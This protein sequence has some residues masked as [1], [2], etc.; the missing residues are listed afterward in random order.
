MSKGK[1]SQEQKERKE[2]LELYRRHINPSLARLLKMMAADRVEFWGRGSVIYDEEGK[3]YID[4]LG[5]YGT[6][7]LGHAHPVVVQAVRRQLSRMP[8]SSKI[9]LNRP[10]ALLAEKIAQLAPSPLQFS[11]FCN[12]GAEAVEGAIKIA[13]LATGK[14]KIISC[15]NA[16]HGKTLGALSVSGRE[17]YREPF[18]PLLPDCVQI[19][20]ND[21]AA[22]EAAIDD[23]TAAFLVEPIQGEG[24]VVVPDLGYLKACAELCRKKGV[25]LVLDEVQTG[26]GRCGRLFCFQNEEI[27]PDILLLGKALGGGVMPLAAIVGTEAVFKSLFPNPLLHTSTFGGN[28]LSC[29]A[30]LAALDVIEC[31]NLVERARVMGDYFIR[32]LTALQE[33]FNEICAS[34]RG[35]G[36]MIGVEVTDEAVGGILM[37]EMLKRGVLVA[38]TLNNPRVIRF[39][40]PLIIQEKEIRF[41]LDALRASLGK[42]RAFL[43]EVSAS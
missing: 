41:V 6:F 13:R 12:S 17:L 30:G 23:R 27:V 32:G 11:F 37:N 19:P 20:F 18:Y 4:C 31:E 26:L 36:L 14:T 40:P 9:L 42:A 25:L 16:F 15:E 29:A 7:N 3:K 28:P 2:T 5:G 43:A 39:E 10:M 24:G 35:A 22:L 21:P 8:L 33:E 1:A 34:V 38:Y